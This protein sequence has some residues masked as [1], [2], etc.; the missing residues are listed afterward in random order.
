MKES[1]KEHVRRLVRRSMSDWLNL[2]LDQISKEMVIQRHTELGNTITRCKTDNKTS[3]NYVFRRLRSIIKFA[4]EVYQTEGKPI[5]SEDPTQCLG[6]R[7][8]ETKVRV[9]L[10][11]DHRLAEFYKLLMHSTRKDCRDF[12]FILLFTALRRRETSMLKWEDIDFKQKIL[13]IPANSTKTGKEHILPITPIVMAILESR[14]HNCSEYV[15]P[16]RDGG[17]LNE[18]RMTLHHL[19][20]AM[21]WHWLLHDLRRTALS[22]ADKSGLPYIAIAK[23]ANHSYRRGM[24]DRYIVVDEEYIRPFLEAMNNRL[25]DLMR[26]SVEQWAAED[27]A[28]RPKKFIATEQQLAEGENSEEKG[29]LEVAEP[30]AEAMEEEEEEIYF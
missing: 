23:I 13:R 24:S 18:P 1:S 15:F 2:P 9:G 30:K 20:K 8:Y 25:L 19:R 21:G 26:T 3:A 7:W 10:I 28:S 5:I 27:K 4:R 11:P 12:I 29:D 6:W 14:R 17:C 22:A 16:G